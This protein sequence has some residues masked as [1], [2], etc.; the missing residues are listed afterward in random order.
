MGFHWPSKGSVQDL[1]TNF[2]KYVK[3]KLTGGTGVHVIFDCYCEYSIKS[4]TRCSRKALVSREHQL[5]LS[6]PLPPQQVALTITKNKT[7]LIDM[8]CDELV[9][10]VELLNLPYSLVVTGKITIPTEV[11]NGLQILRP[12]GNWTIYY[13]NL[14]TY[15]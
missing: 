1:V 12:D 6:S 10:T 11:C 8:I 4:G 3:G 13:R 15:L 14:N 2:V 9:S 5:Y 7:Q